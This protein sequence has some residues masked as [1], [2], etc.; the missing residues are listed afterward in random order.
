[1]SHSLGSG[2]GAKEAGILELDFGEL[3]VVV[4]LNDEWHSQDQEGGAGDPRRLANATEELLGHDGGFE[5][6]VLGV[7]DKGRLGYIAAGLGSLTFSLET[8]NGMDGEGDR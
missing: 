2:S 4:H 6:G 5:G 7:D 8:T 3:L 1:M